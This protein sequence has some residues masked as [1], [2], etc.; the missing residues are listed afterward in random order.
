MFILTCRA[1]NGLFYIIAV[2]VLMVA[3]QRCQ[4]EVLHKPMNEFRGKTSPIG[5]PPASPLGAMQVASACG[6]SLEQVFE[7]MLATCTSYLFVMYRV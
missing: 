5:K 7:Q 6:V 1:L 2:V 4:D 3:V